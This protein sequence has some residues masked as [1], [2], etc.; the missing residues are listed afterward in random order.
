MTIGHVISPC[1]ASASARRSSWKSGKIALF[2]LFIFDRFL[3]LDAKRFSQPHVFRFRHFKGSKV[4]SMA[5]DA[6]TSIMA[7]SKVDGK[8][9]DG[10]N[11]MDTDN[12]QHVSKADSDSDGEYHG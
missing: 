10:S 2:F 6:R 4:L 8:N 1:F 5:S 9:K 12:K 11:E 7:H 3:L